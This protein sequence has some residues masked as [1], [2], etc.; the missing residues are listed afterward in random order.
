MPGY[1]ENVLREVIVACMR[2]NAEVSRT[3]K[4]IKAKNSSKTNES[5]DKVF[6]KCLHISAPDFS[7]PA[8][9]A[10]YSTIAEQET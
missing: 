6:R 9:F 5:C 1:A 4:A 3:P 7:M 10:A 2:T 8:L